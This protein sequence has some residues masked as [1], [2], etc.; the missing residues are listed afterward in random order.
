[1][2]TQ[3][4]TLHFFVDDTQLSHCITNIYTTPLSFGITAWDTPSSSVEIVSFL[5][6]KKASVDNRIKCGEYDW[7]GRKNDLS[8]E[9]SCNNSDGDLDEEEDGLSSEDCSDSCEVDSDDN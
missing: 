8:S 2:N 7:S 1:L 4:K 3:T 5:L 9:D 6:L